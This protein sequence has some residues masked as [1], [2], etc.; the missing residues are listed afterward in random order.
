MVACTLS[1]HVTV[2]PASVSS[3]YTSAGVRKG[4]VSSAGTCGGRRPKRAR[5]AGRR[6]GLEPEPGRSRVDRDGLIQAQCGPRRAPRHATAGD[7]PLISKAGSLFQMRY[8]LYIGNR[9]DALVSPRKSEAQ[10]PRSPTMSSTDYYANLAD[11][12]DNEALK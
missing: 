12:R 1:V 2:I 8:I 10:S 4:S 7:S 5:R 3:A 11:V 9:G 6:L